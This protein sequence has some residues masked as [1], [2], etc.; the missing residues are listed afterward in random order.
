MRRISFLVTFLSF[1]LL[2]MLA[3]C[4][5]GSS[6]G[7]AIAPPSSTTLDAGAASIALSVS[8]TN[9]S[10]NAGVTW[11]LSPT[12]GCGS[13]S[14]ITTTSVTYA[15]PADTLTANCT[16]TI[17]A[18]SVS[19]TSKTNA[20]ALTI[21]AISV[22]ISSSAG[23]TT[24][25]GAG[26]APITLTA[27]LSNEAT[28][29]DTVNWTL[30]PTN[31]GTVAPA[32][33]GTHPAVAP[34]GCGT[35]GTPVVSGNTSAV[36]YT[37]P[38]DVYY[39][40]CTA[41]ITAASSINGNLSTVAYTIS[42]I[43]VTLTAPTAAVTEY[44]NQ[45]NVPLTA[46]IAN[47]GASKGL[48]WA[49]SPTSCGALSATTG[50]SVS[51]IPPA[52]P[53]AQCT[54]V[55]TV[56][57]V[58]DGTKF[59]TAP[60]ITINPNVTIAWNPT[61]TSPVSEG[62]AQSLVVNVSNDVTNSGLVNWAISPTSGCGSLSATTGATVNFSSNPVSANCTA[63]ITAIS[64]ADLKPSVSAQIVVNAT[65]V[66]ITSPLTA[67]SVANSV[68]VP[69][70]ASITND[71][72][73]SG[74][75]WSLTPGTGCTSSYGWLSANSGTSTTYTAPPEASLPTACTVT[76]KAF[77]ILDPTKSASLAVTSNPITLGAL[78]ATVGGSAQ[79][80]P[81]TV[82][83]SSG[84]VTLYESP[85]FDP[86]GPADIAW[87]NSNNTCG[88]LGASFVSSGNS[89]VVFTPAASVTTNCTTTITAASQ[90]DTT[91]TVSTT[92]TVVPLTVTITTPISSPTT[93]QEGA[94]QN[95]VATVL[96]DVANKGVNWTLNPA[97]ACGSL[98]STTTA[99][100]G[101]AIL[102]TAP[103]PP[104]AGCTVVATATSLSDNTKF[105]STTLNITP[106]VISVSW[107]TTPA[108]NLDASNSLGNSQT[109]YSVTLTND[110][111]SAGVNWSSSN[112]QCGSSNGT[113]G[114]TSMTFTATLDSNLTTGTNCVT[115]ITATSI[116][117][118]TKKIT[119]TLNVLPIAV[120]LTPSGSQSYTAGAAAQTFSATVNN[121]ALS[122][123]GSGG[124][125]VTWSLSNT[126]GCGSLSNN[127]IT[128][129]TYT[130][131]G[132]LSSS[133][134]TELIATS[135]ADSTKSN[136]DTI[137]VNPTGVTL[138]ID[139][140]NGGQTTSTYGVVG[141]LY[142]LPLD[143]QGGSGTYT[144]YVTASGAIPPGL[145]YSTSL[146]ALVGT[147][148]SGAA[149]NSYTFTV[150][151]TDS[152]NNTATSTTPVSVYI[153][154]AP[155]HQ[156]DS[157]LNG[158]YTCLTKG[159]V[160]NSGSPFGNA[161]V[162]SQPFTGTG[163]FTGGTYDMS[164]TGG[165]YQGVVVSGSTS[166]TVNI[167]SDNHG[168]I[169]FTTTPS[170]G[171]ASTSTWAV[172]LNGLAG[173]TATQLSGIE[174]DDL[175]ATPSGTRGSAICY[176][177]T[178]SAFAPGTVDSEGYV[179]ALA[180]VGDNGSS[181]A[182]VGVLNLG[183]SGSISGG[184][185]D[186]IKADGT[187][188]SNSSV[189]GSFTTP[190]ATTG[191]WTITA[192]G[193]GSTNSLILYQ[194]DAKRAVAITTDGAGSMQSGN[195]RKQLQSTYSNSASLN[196]NFVVYYHATQFDSTAT[197]NGYSAQI[198]QGTGNGTTGM[199]INYSISDNVSVSGG[200]KSTP[201]Q[202]EGT[203]GT[204]YTVSVAS[205]GRALLTP[206]GST[207][208]V[209]FYFYDTNS[210]LMSDATSGV[211]VGW[212]EAQTAT[213][214]TNISGDYILYKMYNSEPGAGDSLGVMTL[215]GGT[216]VG[217][218]DSA[219][220]GYYFWEAPL[221]PNGSSNPTYP[222]FGSYEQFTL[223]NTGSNT[224]I[225]CMAI[226]ATKL[227]CISNDDSPNINILLQ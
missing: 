17:T 53:G 164:F 150:K 196:G 79:T 190:N 224:T 49:L 10:K 118:P 101:A 62:A 48:T 64:A 61:P 199:T 111:A 69:F 203:K 159:F 184:Q 178:T 42:A 177:D 226:T 171:T 173:T 50:T 83:Q 192:S 14:N 4:G 5:G 89:Q 85:S 163:T 9:D 220:Q 90:L 172:S 137:T 31:S 24:S 188:S 218:Q 133:C 6:I 174:M 143:T 105:A 200:V 113:S 205:N 206:S 78:T 151:V 207:S 216:I 121:D 19:N 92:I 222:S 96:G 74:I 7:V 72:S 221:Q 179:F 109:P 94:T 215:S 140:T 80:L 18:T 51:Y 191:R 67:P 29:T 15:P 198:L 122:T 57:S 212:V 33:R 141:Q 165:T 176:Q 225:D 13:L 97:T 189:S 129:V 102:Y 128:G 134:S 161:I 127:S 44:A 52:N 99:A 70:T 35:L 114:S 54:A 135:V 82:G 145:S 11:S 166:G 77:S 65:V 36:V 148:T 147:P 193:G 2:A 45:G 28:N 149:G 126:S 34:T 71:G 181:R 86:N 60:T 3:A 124:Y 136:F 204:L 95:L 138:T 197:V 30:T 1:V 87:S 187:T 37:P 195:V 168:I 201:T 183:A 98:P 21:K 103:A 75:G 112:N 156:H 38:T 76:V 162:S 146:N 194:I 93:V 26:A 157:Y 158:T 47:D 170:V 182:T 123:T 130:P 132:S 41:T 160:D 88:T 104:V 100:S 73:S 68:Q 58:T 131:P 208:S 110:Y 91:K 108:A 43:T 107:T 186:T 142:E 16:A 219:G 22:G 185:L 81:A 25:F 40:T 115:T 217:K 202:D 209:Y 20:V 56:S 214:T 211:N 106:P 175:G 153:A 32:R 119:A 210:A 144:S 23:S 154:A 120:A 84:A 223:G 8:V 46:T 155:N 117:D 180:G 39:T 167:G 125:G 116:T 12:S 66:N 213:G 169:T 27:T 55:I 139:P 63:T 227:V 59:I 152:S